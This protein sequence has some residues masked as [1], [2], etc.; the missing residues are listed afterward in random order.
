MARQHRHILAHHRFGQH[1]QL[2]EV[3]IESLGHIARHFQVL[4]L[5]TPDR[6]IVSP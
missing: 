4:H 6:H 2:T 1:E 3:M 5:V